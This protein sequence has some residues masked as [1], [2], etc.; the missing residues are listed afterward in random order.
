LQ[1]VGIIVAGG[2]GAVCAAKYAGAPLNHLGIATAF[3]LS[4]AMAVYA[5]RDISGAHLNP[6]ITASLYV[7][8]DCPAGIVAPYMLSQM[9][10]ATVGALINYAAYSVSHMWGLASKP[11]TAFPPSV[12]LLAL[13]CNTLHRLPSNPFHRLPSNVFHHPRCNVFHHPPAPLWA[14]AIFAVDTMFACTLNWPLEGGRPD[15]SEQYAQACLFAA[16]QRG[17]ANLE[18]AEKLVRG[19]KG[20]AASFAGAFGMIPNKALIRTPGALVGEIVMTA[21]LAF[22]VFAISDPDK[23]VPSGAAPVLVGATVA[24]IIFPGGPVTGCG[25]NPARDLGPRLVTAATG[26]GAATLSSGWWVYTIGPLIGGILGG[27]LYNA[28][29]KKK[30]VVEADGSGDSVDAA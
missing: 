16:A 21:A 10:G 30:K 11:P 19:T 20:S 9:V 8:S 22:M 23:S 6:A 12:P 13:Q 24:T 26:W 27:A 2:C 25:M 28:T 14:D 4:V 29:M 5:T 18:K 15:C 7:N 1:G 3:G 17:I